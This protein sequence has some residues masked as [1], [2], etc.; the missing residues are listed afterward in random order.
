MALD[1]IPEIVVPGK[2]LGR[3]IH[4]EARMLARPYAGPRKAITSVQHV[5]H[6]PILDQG[7]VGSCTG[8]AATGALGTSPVFDALPGKHIALDENEALRLYSAAEVIDGDG[9]YP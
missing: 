5:R 2:R 4:L 6:I 8:N 3:H 7:D 1:R 9:P